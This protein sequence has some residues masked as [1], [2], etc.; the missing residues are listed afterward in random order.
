MLVLL[1]DGRKLVGVLRSYDQFGMFMVHG[2]CGGEFGNM[3]FDDRIQSRACGGE[4]RK[5]ACELRYAYVMWSVIMER[6][7][8]RNLMYVRRGYVYI[9]LKLVALNI[10]Y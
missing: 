7:G 2:S 3:C 9:L 10:E 5:F 6:K 4:E 1:R 8:M